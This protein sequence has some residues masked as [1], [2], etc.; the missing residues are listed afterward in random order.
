VEA[1]TAWARDVDGA[2]A[3]LIEAS[4]TRATLVVDG[5][6]GSTGVSD[7]AAAHA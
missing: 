6:G 4:R 1:A 2:N 5:S 3:V 7:L